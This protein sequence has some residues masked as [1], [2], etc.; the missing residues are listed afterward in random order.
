VIE[1]TPSPKASTAFVDPEEAQRKRSGEAELRALEQASVMPEVRYPAPVAAPAAAVV[2]A[3]EPAQ[4]P[5]AAP[6]TTATSPGTRRTP[7][8]AP[9]SANAAAEAP[10]PDDPWA[11]RY[12]GRTDFNTAA[13]KAS[14]D[15][16]TSSPSE[17]AKTSSGTRLPVRLDSTVASSPSGPV[18]AV[19]T[20][21][22]ELDGGPLPAGTQLHGVTE[23]AQGTRL[24]VRF[25]FA[26]TRSGQHALRGVAMGTD[27]RAGIPGVKTL[28]GVT[29][30]G[31]G[32]VQ[33]AVDSTAGIIADVVGDNPAGAA[34]RGAGNASRTKS[35]RLNS[36]E[37]VVEAK[38]GTRFSVYVD[39][40][41]GGR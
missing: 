27:G 40:F 24:L 38:R 11:A 31:A 33:G 10:D 41:G 19:L 32:A 6:P 2:A 17:P 39:T 14:G 35:D 20:A 36:A 28:G 37:Y 3:A 9:A 21:A 12:G 26:K 8:A 1:S 15:S 13:V 25:Q 22:A 23:G 30:V 34:I 7:R 18:I 29:D 4:A 5:V 16:S